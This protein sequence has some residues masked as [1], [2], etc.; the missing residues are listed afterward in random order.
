MGFSGQEYWS[1]LPFPSPGDLP[2][3]GIGLG[4]PALQADSLPSE[5]IGKPEWRRVGGG[6][7]IHPAYIAPHP[8][9]TSISALTLQISIA[10]HESPSGASHRLT[11]SH[12]LHQLPLLYLPPINLF[13][14]SHVLALAGLCLECLV[15]LSNS[16]SPFITQLKSSLLQEAFQASFWG[17]PLPSSCD[18]PAYLA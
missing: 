9:S 12:L 6:P 8:T 5:P 16:Y 15:S 11:C 4:S 14:H 17:I 13:S 10:P 1:G 7:C 3:P 18:C 2:N